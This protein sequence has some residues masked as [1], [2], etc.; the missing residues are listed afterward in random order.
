LRNE[1]ISSGLR[2]ALELRYIAVTV[3]TEGLPRA[4]I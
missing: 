3:S 4:I 1:L 2:Q